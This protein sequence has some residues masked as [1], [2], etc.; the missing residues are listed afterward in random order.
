VSSLLKPVIHAVLY[1]VGA[2]VVSVIGGM[3]RLFIA[4]S[5]R[6]NA[7]SAIG[8]DIPTFVKHVSLPIAVVVFVVALLLTYKQR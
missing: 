6:L 3:V 7:R 1:S 4:A 2:C 8:L 5:R